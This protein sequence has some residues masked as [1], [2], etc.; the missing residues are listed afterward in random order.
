MNANGR[1]FRILDPREHG[2]RPLVVVR[3]WLR[4]LSILAD[5]IETV[6]TAKSIEDKAAGCCAEWLQHLRYGLFSR[7]NLA[8]FPTRP[9]THRSLE[10]PHRPT[11]LWS[12]HF[13][14][15]HLE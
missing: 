10:P 4:L 5:E 7:M 2:K 6:G 13:G 11:N 3:E 14:A 1:G 12:A 9:L 8:V 15:T